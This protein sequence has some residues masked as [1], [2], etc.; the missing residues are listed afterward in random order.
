MELM[1]NITLAVVLAFTLVHWAP[2]AEAG[3]CAILKQWY[4]EYTVA[5]H[6]YRT[7]REI[8]HYADLQG[9]FMARLEQLV[10]NGGHWLDAGAGSAFAMQQV[11]K[12]LQNWGKPVPE[13][14]A[15]AISLSTPTK[16]QR[17][18]QFEKYDA[19][20]A[21]RELMA[22]TEGRFRSLLG[23]VGKVQDGVIG[24]PESVDLITD[25]M[26]PF[27]YT[28]NIHQVLNQYLRLLKTGGTIHIMSVE[29]NLYS[30]RDGKR[31]DFI[32]YLNALPGIEART[33]FY[34]GNQAFEIVKTASGA[35]VPAMRMDM[36]QFQ[37]RNPPVR[38]FDLETD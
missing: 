18:W 16:R 35:K 28:L 14:L 19:A 6:N 20:A 7:D 15:T 26:G 34:E 27:S 2:P 32:D 17:G 9:Q 23:E 1:R 8:E 5:T 38:Y 12:G 30:R 25:F 21:H 22:E 24:K 4:Y 37:F 11:M 29:W 33:T 3:L 36:D 10:R 31:V 13:F